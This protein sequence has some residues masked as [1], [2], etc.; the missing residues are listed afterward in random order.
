MASVCVDEVTVPGVLKRFVDPS[1]TDS[2]VCCSD[3]GCTKTFANEDASERELLVYRL[4]LPYVP[5]LLAY[6]RRARSITTERVGVPLGTPWN[7]GIPLLS[8][9]LASSSRWRR[10]RRIRRLHRRFRKDTGYFHNDVCYKNVLIEATTGRMYLIDFERAGPTRADANVD[11]ILSRTPPSTWWVV[12]PV[13]VIVLLVV[14][15]T[16]IGW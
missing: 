8:V 16:I 3:V 10:N 1:M 11:G 7:S 4:Y 12:L 14:C 6:N 5:R 13:G 15:C 9:L 2:T